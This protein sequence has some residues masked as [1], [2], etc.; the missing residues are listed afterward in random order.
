MRILLIH[1]D[2]LNYN[3]KNKTPVAEEIEDAKKQGAF[4]ESLVVFTAV[5]KDD[6]NNPQGIVKNLVKEVIKTND[7]VKAEN[8]VLYP[9][10]HL[11]SS[12]SSPK[13]AVQVLK[14]AEEALDAEGLNVKRVP[15]GWYK[16]FEISCK[17]HPLSE[18]SRTITAEEEEE[19]EVEKKPSS[20]S[21]LDGDKIIDID[22]FKFENDQL[23]K[24]VSYELGTGA[25]DAGEPPHVKLMRE[26]ELC[27]YESASD[28]GN[29]KWFPKGRLVR[30]LLAD[31]VY[32]LVVDQGA[33]P[34]ETPIFYDLDNEAINVH[35]A[36][37]GER[38]YRTDTKKNLMLRFA[39]CFG[40]FRVMADPFITWKNLPAKLYEL[41]TYSF[42]FE[43]KGEVVGLKRLRAF[44]MP[45][46][47]SFCA[48][49]NSTLEEFSKQ[50]DMCIQTGVDLD[51]NYEIIFRATK[52]FY[53]EN[54]DWMY[55]I[56]KKIGK[57]VLLEILPE[58]KHY[59]SC[60][61]DFAAID[62]LG[63]PIENPTVQIDVESGKRFDI[64]YLG[65]DGKEHYPTIL[66][67]SPT[68]SIERVICSLLE[69]TAIEL[70]E[71]A[72]MLPTWLSP[73]EVRIIT[74]GEDHKDFAN[75]LYDKI[76]AENIRV[77]VDDR[78]ESVGKK[79]R[80]AAT[81]WI[82][83][84]FVVG[85]NEK[86]SGVFSVTV[87]ETGEKVDMTVDELIKEILD[88]TKGMPYRGLPLP[89]DISTRINFQ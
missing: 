3:V 14:D 45:D 35:A 49:M 87:R 55:S 75:E 9:Y 39:C 7:Q 73:I 1:S 67:C 76:N 16:A 15:F 4:D 80:N 68:G 88:K 83:Y 12:L 11:S 37:F 41:S 69:K 63:R 79:I 89:K 30:D 65:E 84:I 66:H 42:R 28:V 77:D 53:D 31:Y 70:D 43:K 22:D 8:I 36:K 17:G 13:V 64:T 5:E 27:D 44:T 50:T 34:I 48:D 20:W 60:K 29:L 86:E 82:P 57:P 25:S 56:G 59:W 24:L 18:L 81:E 10:A 26:K 52:D 85:D 78:D 38:Q 21:I 74:V 71:K 40:A 47:H 62:Y 6:E 19:E 72:P 32:N 46:F 51:V 61:I 54:K 58:R 2:Y 23:E 33:M